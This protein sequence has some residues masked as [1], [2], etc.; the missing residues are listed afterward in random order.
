M[1]LVKVP[2]HNYFSDRVHLTNIWYAVEFYD[3]KLFGQREVVHHL[4]VDLY[5][6]LETI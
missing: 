4:T 3:S 6:K 5:P 1:I 2:V